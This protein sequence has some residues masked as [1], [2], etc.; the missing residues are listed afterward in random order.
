[1][2]RF[3]DMTDREI[4]Q[5][6]L[7]HQAEMGCQDLGPEDIDPAIRSGTAV[8]ERREHAFAVV[9]PESRL[10]AGSPLPHLWLI[11]VCPEM[12]SKGLGRRFVTD[13]VDN[14]GSTLSMTAIVA[15]DRR[16]R[17]FERC[18]FRTV[19]HD[20]RNGWKKMQAMRTSRAA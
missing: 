11:Y 9:N 20:G 15:G 1:M 16:A 18:G 5:F 14:Y 12:R 2:N 4:I 13:L 3:T 6:A 19:E 8:I 7:Y 10:A 17:F